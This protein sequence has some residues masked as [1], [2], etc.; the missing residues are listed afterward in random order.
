M[1]RLLPVVL[2]ILAVLLCGNAWAKPIFGVRGGLN[3]AN[4]TETNDPRNASNKTKIGLLFGGAGE[5]SLSESHTVTLRLE[6]L[7]V[8]KGWKESGT[9]KD[10][11]YGL[12]DYKGTFTVDEFVLAPFLVLHFPRG[13]VTPFIQAGPELGFNTSDNA[14]AR[15]EGVST[16]AD[17]EDWSSANLGINIG[18][19]IAVP[20]G[21]GEVVF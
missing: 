10:P 15:V 7:W 3:L 12:S 1:K 20:A 11:Y 18:G 8:Q 19:G 13:G 5:F 14:G 6:L 9:V 2:L 21:R 4:A 17:I 16:S